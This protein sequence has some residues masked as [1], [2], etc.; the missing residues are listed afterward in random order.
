MTTRRLCAI[1]ILVAKLVFIVEFSSHIAIYRR[2]RRTTS[3]MGPADIGIVL[4]NRTSDIS[5]FFEEL[6][7]GLIATV[8]CL[9]SACLSNNAFANDEIRSTIVQISGPNTKSII[10]KFNSRLSELNSSIVAQR[11][12]V[13]PEFITVK[14]QFE[15]LND[16]AALSLMRSV[17]IEAANCPDQS[18]FLPAKER[19]DFI[20]RCYFHAIDENMWNSINFGAWDLRAKRENKITVVS[21]GISVTFKKLKQAEVSLIEQIV[22]KMNSELG[23]TNATV[24]S[25]M[26]MGVFK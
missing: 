26:E 5:Y 21:Y 3:H 10:A 11:Q 9:F 13:F 14:S 1:W 12:N 25:R 7:M 2:Q 18:E 16:R 15:Q 24:P 6:Q 23:T 17:A 20:K 22:V 4:A 19:T 8:I